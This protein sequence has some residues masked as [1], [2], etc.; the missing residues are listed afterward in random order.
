MESARLLEEA[1]GR[2]AREQA[3]GEI[4]ASLSRTS[5]VENILQTTVAEL[6]RRL[7]STQSITIEMSNTGSSEAGDHEDR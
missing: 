7:P 5:E 6:G 4:A 1:Q 2:A 3:I